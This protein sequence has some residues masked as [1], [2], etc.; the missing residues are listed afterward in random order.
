MRLFL[1]DFSEMQEEVSVVQPERL[2]SF[3]R[4]LLVKIDI[5]FRKARYY[6]NI[7]S[8]ISSLLL[9]NC[10]FQSQQYREYN[11]PVPG[12]SIT[13]FTIYC[14]LSI[15]MSLRAIMSIIVHEMVFATI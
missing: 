13:W 3:Y 1:S 2:F 7:Q 11:G 5:C 10:N 9:H 4:Y 12:I 15:S 8:D 6:S 14:S